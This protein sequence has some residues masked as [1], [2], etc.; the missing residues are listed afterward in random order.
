MKN[1]NKGENM[2]TTRVCGRRGDSPIEKG[3]T[4]RNWD[5][6]PFTNHNLHKPCKERFYVIFL[7]KKCIFNFSYFWNFFIFYYVHFLI[8]YFFKTYQSL[9]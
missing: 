4:L 2:N 6:R 5:S 9:R 1:F 8:L 7:N 3:S